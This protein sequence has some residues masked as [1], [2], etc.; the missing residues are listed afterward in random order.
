PRPDA[1]VRAAQEDHVIRRGTVAGACH[2][3]LRTPAVGGLPHAGSVAAPHL[4][5]EA[6]GEDLV[7]AG[8]HAGQVAVGLAPGAA[9]PDPDAAVG[10]AEEDDI[11][12]GISVAGV[13]DGDLDAPAPA[14]GPGAV[15]IAPKLTVLSQTE[16][17]AVTA[18]DLGEGGNTQD[19]RLHRP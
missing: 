8:R 10:S 4:T 9:V 17:L 18:G 3:D 11:V 1:I 13:G 16:N 6:H 7:V 12:R 15:A 19:W 5:V 14:G 2:D